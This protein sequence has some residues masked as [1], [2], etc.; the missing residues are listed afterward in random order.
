MLVNIY[1]C[2]A[3]LQHKVEYIQSIPLIFFFTYDNFRSKYINNALK[4]K[5]FEVWA[6]Y[7]FELC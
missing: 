2:Q 7:P 1:L 6:S 5:V 3:I 4:Y